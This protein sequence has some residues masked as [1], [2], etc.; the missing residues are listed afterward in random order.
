MTKFFNGPSRAAPL[1]LAAVALLAGC[2]TAQRPDAA[3][4]V[5]DAA[6]IKAPAQWYTVLPHGGGTA[7]LATW[8]TQLGD[9]LLP[10]LITAAQNESA[11]LAAARTRIEQSRAALVSAGGALLPQVNASASGSRGVQTPK[12]GVATSLNAGLQASWEMDLFGGGRA[13]RDASA[14]RLESA[15]AGW[16]SARVSLAAE[17]A[18]AYYSFRQCEN[19]LTLTQSDAASRLETARLTDLSAKAGFNA[20]ANAALARASAA[21]A[22]SSVRAQQA[23]CDVLVKAL[24]A[25]SDLDEPALRKKLELNKAASQQNR[26]WAALFSIANL[27]AQVLMQ[28][29]DLAAAQRNV[30][31]ASADIVSADAKRL[32]TLTL[33]GSVG[34]ARVSS[35]GSAQEG[36]TWSLGPLAI[37]LP[38]IDQ[39]RNAANLRAAQAAYDEAVVSLRASARNAVREVEEA[40]VNLNSVAE[41]QGD[42]Q[43]AAQ[44]YKTALDAAQTR[45]R[46]GLGS[47][48]ELEDVRRTAL[49]SQQSLL[50]LER[51]RVAAWISLYRAA[52][53]GWDA[54]MLAQTGVQP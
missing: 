4:A 32:P 6:Q 2:A 51:E 10:E 42:T 9:P 33:N 38:I 37:N 25:L 8:W 46:S 39:G 41:R 30:A 26:A 5:A 24:V 31:A 16:H 45:Y 18:G 20:P 7:T 34:G 12:A 29:P 54:A 3:K 1:C 36:I 49:A 15:Q 50:Q 40:L 47:L 52:G 53:G 14:L 21:D 27:P 35:G 22:A 28:R 23:Q 11:T 48:V 43:A 17:T 13:T 19:V 44:G